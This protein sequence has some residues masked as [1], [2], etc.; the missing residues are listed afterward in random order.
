MVV[1]EQK[2]GGF[3]IDSDVLYGAETIDVDYINLSREK[4]EDLLY[5]PLEYYFVDYPGEYDM[6]GIFVKA[7]LG[8]SNKMSYILKI[9]QERIA[10]VQ[11]TDI[12]DRDDI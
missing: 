4:G 7:M 8:R 1:V 10:I 5:K 2:D 12:L 3:L 9:A 11:T 6:N